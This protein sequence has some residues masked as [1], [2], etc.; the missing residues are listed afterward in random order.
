MGVINRYLIFLKNK[1]FYKKP[2]LAIWILVLK[3]LEFGSWG[4]GLIFSKVK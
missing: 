1:R 2:V 4:L 3:T